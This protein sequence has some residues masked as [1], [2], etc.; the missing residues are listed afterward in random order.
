MDVSDSYRRD[1]RCTYEHVRISMSSTREKFIEKYRNTF[2]PIMFWWALV[3]G[4]NTHSTLIML[5]S[6]MG[7][8]DLYLDCVL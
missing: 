4:T 6:I 5:F 1:A 7:R 3:G 2:N 8:F